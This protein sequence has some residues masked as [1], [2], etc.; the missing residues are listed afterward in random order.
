MSSNRAIMRADRILEVVARSADPLS[1]SEIARG[2]GAPLSST[3]DLLNDLAGRGYLVRADKAY[4]LGPR[5]LTLRLIAAHADQP[6]IGRNDLAALAEHVG[7]PVALAVLVGSDIIYLGTSGEVSPRAQAVVGEYRP[8]PLLRTAA[9]RAFLAFADSA[10]RDRLIAAHT[11]GE[12]AQEFRREIPA[13][14]RR[15]Y[16]VSDGLA[17]PEIRACGVPV[18]DRGLLAG[19]VVIVGARESPEPGHAVD[20]AAREARKWLLASGH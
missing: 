10:D 2:V 13:I 6:P 20:R 14:R 15:G 16:A 5:L 12:Q 11:S 17:D 8:R 4:R 9:G 18:F 1:L 19:V 3:L 7:T